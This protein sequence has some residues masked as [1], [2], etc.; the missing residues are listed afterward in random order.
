M[1]HRNIKISF[2]ANRT[3]TKPVVVPT[4]FIPY[5][6][7][8]VNIIAV[9]EMRFHQ[10][11]A[12][13]GHTRNTPASRAFKMI[14]ATKYS[15]NVVNV[16]FWRAFVPSEQMTPLGMHCNLSLPAS[17]EEEERQRQLNINIS[18]RNPRRQLTDW[19]IAVPSSSST[20]DA[21]GRTHPEG[22]QIPRFKSIPIH[23]STRDEPFRWVII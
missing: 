16:H 15:F 20:I 3:V 22:T 19:W 1:K 8:H 5:R 2:T 14:Q 4:D 9:V 10:H 13:P 6:Q 23:T 17:R 7:K 21:E 11:Q 18:F 12:R